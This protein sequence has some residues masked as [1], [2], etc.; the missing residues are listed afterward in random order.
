MNLLDFVEYPLFKDYSRD[1]VIFNKQCYDFERWDKW[2]DIQKEKNDIK[3]VLHIAAR[4]FC[5]FFLST[6]VG[7]KSTV[8]GI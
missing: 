1:M 8:Q 5:F 3:V 2:L 7:I 6:R 4:F